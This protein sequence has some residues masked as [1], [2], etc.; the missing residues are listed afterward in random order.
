MELLCAALREELAKLRAGG[1]GRARH[2]EQKKMFVRDRIDALL[3][4]G[5]PFLELSQLAAYGMYDDKAP[6]A[7]LVT[8]VGRVAGREGMS[9]AT[10]ATAEGRADVP[11][12]V[13]THPRARDVAPTKR[14]PAPARRAAV[15]HAR[16]DSRHGTLHIACPLR[17]LEWRVSPARHHAP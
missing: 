1:S 11:T 14:P 4:P 3:D 2:A 9:V 10:D 15:T 7:G 8:G 5:S 13:Q 17:R 12:P 16:R 6:A